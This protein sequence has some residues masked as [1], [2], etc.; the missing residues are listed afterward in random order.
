MKC[1]RLLQWH[2]IVL[3]ETLWQ[4][5]KLHPFQL[6]TYRKYMVIILVLLN[7]RVMSILIR[8]KVET[9]P[10]VYFNSNRVYWQNKAY[11]SGARISHHHSY[12]PFNCWKA[13]KIGCKL[14]NSTREAL[15]HTV[16]STDGLFVRS[17]YSKGYAV[18]FTIITWRCAYRNINRPTHW[19]SR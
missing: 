10:G 9:V 1:N 5:E 17:S 13:H 16:L 4:H 12:V 19:R 3:W 7:L 2:R 11:W 14:R 6:E 15:I 8:V 18:V